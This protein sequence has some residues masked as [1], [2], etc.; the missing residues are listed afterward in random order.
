MK[1]INLWMIIMSLLISP[2]FSKTQV[3]FTPQEQC[4]PMVLESIRNAQKYIW[5]QAYYFTSKPVAIALVKAHK[6]GVEVRVV[7]DS[8]QKNDTYGVLSY[9]TRCGIPVQIDDKVKIAH[10]KVMILDGLVV[11]TGSY[12]WTDAAEKSNAENLLEITQEQETIDRYI[13]NFKRRADK[14]TAFEPIKPVNDNQ[15]EM[16]KK[17]DALKKESEKKILNLNRA[18]LKGLNL[19]SKK[20]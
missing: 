11:L 3:C 13:G 4:L 5:V 12:N 10:S 15:E 8:S 6:R 2:S 20:K 17:E 14:S 1:R 16:K 9:L 19:G 7:V 18:F